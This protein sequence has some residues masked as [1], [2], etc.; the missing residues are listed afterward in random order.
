MP[1]PFPA[2]FESVLPKLQAGIGEGHA[3]E[4]TGTRAQ[5]K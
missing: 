5:G 1:A 3:A 4:V 2:D